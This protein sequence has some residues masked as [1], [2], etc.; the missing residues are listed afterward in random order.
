MIHVAW[1]RPS[2]HCKAIFLQLKNKFRKSGK[3]KRNTSVG[4]MGKGKLLFN[5]Y[6]EDDNALEINV[7]GG[8]T[9]V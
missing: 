1:Q 3:E 7:D 2:Q 8:C 6:R 5:E 4:E 9:I